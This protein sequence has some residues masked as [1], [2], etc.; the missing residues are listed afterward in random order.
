MR[1]LF[2][3]ILM[4][5]IAVALILVASNAFEQYA[6]LPRQAVKAPSEPEATTRQSRAVAPWVR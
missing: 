2:S 5:G 6:Q 1:G 3:G 4:V